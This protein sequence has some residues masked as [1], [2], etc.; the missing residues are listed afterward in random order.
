MVRILWRR[1]VDRGGCGLRRVAETMSAHFL[2]CG[3]EYERWK[4]SWQKLQFV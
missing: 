1:D 4:A 3:A 2:N